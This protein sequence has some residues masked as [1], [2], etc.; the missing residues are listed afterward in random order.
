MSSE[1]ATIFCP[2]CGQKITIPTSLEQV[3]CPAC[4]QR[5]QNPRF[6]AGEGDAVVATPAA[7]A[8]PAPAMD[9]VMAQAQRAV[10][11]AQRAAAQAA[12]AAAM[13]KDAPGVSTEDI[14]RAQQAAEQSAQAAS[15]ATR[16]VEQAASAVVP[17]SPEAESAAVAQPEPAP[18]PEPA[19]QP[20]PEPAPQIP[21]G[22]EPDGTIRDRSTG[23]G[24]FVVRPLDGWHVTGTTLMRTNTS[25]RPYVANVELRDQTGGIIK[26]GMGPAGMRQ[27][28]ALKA[29]T[30]TYGSHLIGIDTTNY[31]EMPELVSAADAII[32]PLVN[33]LGGTNLTFVEQYA[34]G[35]L[36]SAQQRAMAQF[37]MISQMSGGSSI[38][39]PFAAIIL[40]T[41]Q[42]IL[43]GSPWKAAS[44]LR[45]EA[46]KDTSG[47]SDVGMP[48]GVLGDLFT[49]KKRKEQQ[50]QKEAAKQTR[51]A[52]S[53]P[54][55]SSY[56]SSGTIMWSISTLAAFAAPAATFDAQLFTHFVPAASDLIYHAD[57]WRLS[58]EVIERENW[59]IQQATQGQLARNQA[60]FQASQ[61]ANRRVQAAYDSYNASVRAAS[62]A[63]H[64][65]FMSSS[66]AQFNSSSPDFSEAI[67][68]VNTYR[69]SDGRDV[70]ISVSADRAYENQAGDVIGWSGAEGPGADWTQLPRQ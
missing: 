3:F 19:P 41:Y 35:D 45:C 42:F 40:R 52:W 67:R 33:G 18:A 15:Q 65:Q 54:E 27:S 43:N 13:V 51:G 21:N 25:S 44:Y 62:D 28:K 6:V 32:P 68:G 4:G 69:T 55:V 48:I 22:I 53:L 46:C 57:V 20:Q 24:I 47:M 8:A 30:A 59:A 61:E 38:G 31:A 39:K 60:A 23:N 12:Q 2:W 10:E 58:Y 63:H 34:P 1:N 29:L 26:L 50:Q 56:V 9:D 70:E 36:D 66:N 64:R 17:I 37:E 5:F 49:S 14:S 11:Q 7:A 16:S